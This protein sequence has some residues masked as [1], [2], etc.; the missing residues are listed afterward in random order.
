V[1]LDEAMKR[2][3]TGEMRNIYQAGRQVFNKDGTPAQV[4]VVSDKILE[5]LMIGRRLFGDDWVEKRS[6]DINVVHSETPQLLISEADAFLLNPEERRALA[7]V[8]RGIQRIRNEAEPLL[9]ESSIIEADEAG[10][11]EI[12][13]WEL[14][15]D[16]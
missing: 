9:L 3:V 5:R 2:G 11:A 8:L 15:G 16:V 1:I 4:R 7:T 10:F 14:L 6:Q 13:D 12:E